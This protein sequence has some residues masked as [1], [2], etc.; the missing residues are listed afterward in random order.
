MKNGLLEVLLLFL[1]VALALLPVALA[2]GAFD[3]KSPYDSC[4]SDF[5][6]THSRC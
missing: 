2:T 4:L 3:R 5:P 1:Y 6:Y